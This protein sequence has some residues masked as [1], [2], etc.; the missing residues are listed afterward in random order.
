[1]STERPLLTKWC[2]LDNATD[3]DQSNRV[4]DNP[5]KL[6]TNEDNDDVEI[7]DYNIKDSKLEKLQK[8]NIESSLE[9][10]N[11]PNKFA[12]FKSV[13][14]P[15]VFNNPETFLNAPGRPS[16]LNLE[17]GSSFG[18]FYPNLSKFSEDKLNAPVRPPP[19]IRSPPPIKK[20]AKLSSV[21]NPQ[22]S[23]VS[24]PEFL[25]SSVRPFDLPETPMEA[26]VRPV[27]DKSSFQNNRYDC[28]R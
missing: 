13:D 1:M 12:S 20:V 5:A 7:F 24:S 27:A 17:S 9:A 23:A 4:A 15:Q 25:K 3:V 19:I 16:K 22:A 2:I 14:A 11:R 18:Q 8:E 6:I 28:W 10:P 21:L 26:P